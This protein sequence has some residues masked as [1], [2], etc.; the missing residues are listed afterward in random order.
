MYLRVYI[1][2]TE[3]DSSHCQDTLSETGIILLTC[4]MG[5]M[6][7]EGE[8][9]QIQQIITIKVPAH[10]NIIKYYFKVRPLLKWHFL[11]SRLGTE[12]KFHMFHSKSAKCGHGIKSQAQ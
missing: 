7:L 4:L 6:A 5:E 11:N 1:Q 9:G 10:M 3:S 12:I 2:K 8:L